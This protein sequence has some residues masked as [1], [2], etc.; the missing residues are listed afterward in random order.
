MSSLLVKAI[1]CATSLFLLSFCALFS[2]LFI[3]AT[4]T[5]G[6]RGIQSQLLAWFHGGDSTLHSVDHIER[7]RREGF[8]SRLQAEDEM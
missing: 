1:V 6:Q 4:E 5:P 2:S 3:H 8:V 7:V